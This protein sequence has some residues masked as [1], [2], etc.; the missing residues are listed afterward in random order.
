MGRIELRQQSGDGE[1]KGDDL[2]VA[3]PYSVTASHGS[4][5]H[6]AHCLL[7]EGDP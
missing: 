3:E 6:Q 7:C 4:T 2:Q 5:E 1:K